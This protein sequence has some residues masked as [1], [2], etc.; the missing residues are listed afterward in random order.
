MSFW[1][2]PRTEHY[3][4]IYNPVTDQFN[5]P[6]FVDGGRPIEWVNRD[7]WMYRYRQRQLEGHRSATPSDESDAHN[8]AAVDDEDDDVASD[9]RLGDRSNVDDADGGIDAD[10]IDVVGG[11]E[12][13]GGADDGIDVS[14]GVDMDRGRF[15]DA[16]D[17][18]D[19]ITQSED[20][21]DDR[22][23][24]P[25]PRQRR[26]RWRH[27]ALD[28]GGIDTS[29]DADG[30]IETS[31]GTGID[32]GGGIE[33]NDGAQEDG[34]DIGTGIDMG[35]NVVDGG[36]ETNGG[37]QD[38]GIDARGGIESRF[39]DAIDVVDSS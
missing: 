11:I 3:D 25:P 34:I 30:G 32:A 12:P 23:D 31:V 22:Q 39:A 24:V 15:A 28:A 20:S 6:W 38:G 33:P 27:G 18:D 17:V 19:L 7:V 4:P 1:H 5:Y 35:I 37:A 26:P 9:G 2:D 10:G 8:G 14:G 13:N 36:I 29:I 21:D 16:I